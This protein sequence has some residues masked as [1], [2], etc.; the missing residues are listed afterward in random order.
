MI[1]SLCCVYFV[2]ELFENG[3]L[4]NW[5][6]W[7]NWGCEATGI[8][9]FSPQRSS[10][11]LVEYLDSV[12]GDVNKENRSSQTSSLLKWEVKVCLPSGINP[13]LLYIPLFVIHDTDSW[14]GIVE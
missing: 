2:D 8:F 9:F 11:L 3:S 13:L 4:E 1:T 6:W 10:L 7:Q 5:Y 12:E 14:E